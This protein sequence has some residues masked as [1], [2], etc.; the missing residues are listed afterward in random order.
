VVYWYVRLTLVNLSIIRSNEREG[1]LY[2]VHLLEALFLNTCWFLLNFSRS[3]DQDNPIHIAP[4]D[5]SDNNL[6]LF[7]PCL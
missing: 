2:A 6:S 7:S 3:L 4:H 5:A 1:L